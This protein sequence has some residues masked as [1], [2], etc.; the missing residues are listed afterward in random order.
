MA[1]DGSLLADGGRRDYCPLALHGFDEISEVID[2]AVLLMEILQAVQV[3]F[4]ARSDALVNVAILL[5]IKVQILPVKYLDGA[6]IAAELLAVAV[7]HVAEITTVVDMEAVGIFV[8]STEAVGDV[9]VVILIGPSVD[10]TGGHAGK[11]HGFTQHEV[12]DIGLVHQQ[13][14]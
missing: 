5:G 6:F 10:A 2:G 1:G 12:Y 3:H 9:A 11:R 14:G 8:D 13:V 4:G 7:M